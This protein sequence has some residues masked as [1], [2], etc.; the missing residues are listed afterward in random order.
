MSIVQHPRP[1]HLLP[2]CRG[3]AV[4]HTSFEY[5]RCTP[6]S[7]PSPSLSLSSA[8]RSHCSASQAR[9]SSP[10]TIAKAASSASVVPGASETLAPRTSS[11]MTSTVQWRKAKAGGT[12][13]SSRFGHVSAAAATVDTADTAR[14]A[15]RLASSP[16]CGAA[17]NATARWIA[18]EWCPSSVAP[19]PTSAAGSCQR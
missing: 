15:A 12:H 13:S 18:M 19:A 16:A 17:S 5:P 2:S 11:Q 10:A 7:H 1:V 3:M 8:L 9:P 6:V 4:L 14:A